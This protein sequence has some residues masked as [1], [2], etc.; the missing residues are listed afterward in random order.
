MLL[1]EVRY[2]IRLG[3]NEVSVV[4]LGASTFSY[5]VGN[6]RVRYSRAAIT[7]S[8]PGS[9]ARTFVIGA[10]SPGAKYLVKRC[11]A[12]SSNAT[13]NDEGMLQFDAT[14]DNGCTNVVSLQHALQ[15]KARSYGPG[16]K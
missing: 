9:G 12:A 8:I 2:G 1:R 5:A 4:P 13:V 14:I 11:D 6:V 16:D 7:V 10:L 3:F 15:A